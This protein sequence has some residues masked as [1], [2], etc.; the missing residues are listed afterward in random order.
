M[1]GSEMALDMV[2]RL[3]GL[4]GLRAAWNDLRVGLLVQAR[5]VEFYE[6]GTVGAAV[7]K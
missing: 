7:G 3:G 4:T 1:L 2:R 6:A 5:T